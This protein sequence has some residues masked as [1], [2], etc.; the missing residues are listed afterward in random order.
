MSNR[1]T[2]KPGDLFMVDPV[3]PNFIATPV[4]VAENG[5]DLMFQYNPKPWHTFEENGVRGLTAQQAEEVLRGEREFPW[6]IYKTWDE[7]TQTSYS[8]PESVLEEIE[9]RQM[10]VEPV[11][12]AATE[13]AGKIK[14]EALDFQTP[15]PDGKLP[16]W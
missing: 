6:V 14:P 10:A 7:Q 2:L 9:R 16:L 8:P 15:P 11:Q 13:E 5:V 3:R 12:G 4:L 1:T